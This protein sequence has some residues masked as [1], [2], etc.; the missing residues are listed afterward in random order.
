[1]S[2]KKLVS[3]VS[4]SLKTKPKE[5]KS[6][7]FNEVQAEFRRLKSTIVM[8]ATMLSAHELEMQMRVH[9]VDP[10]EAVKIHEE[11]MDKIKK[12]LNLA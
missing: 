9:G 2:L 1:M 6:L 7:D 5:I 10:R 3:K 8:L 4:K 11:V 12:S